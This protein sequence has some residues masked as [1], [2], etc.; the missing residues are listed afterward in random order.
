MSITCEM[1]AG[2][3]VFS[4]SEVLLYCTFTPRASKA[5]KSLHMLKQPRCQNTMGNDQCYLQPNCVIAH[6][7]VGQLSTVFFFFF[8]AFV[9]DTCQFCPSHR[10][11]NFFLMEN[12]L[13]QP[14]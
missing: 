7:Q 9:L 2:H 6:L 14:L 8:K 1:C 12:E 11:L 3:K 13:L 4:H 5:V 10:S